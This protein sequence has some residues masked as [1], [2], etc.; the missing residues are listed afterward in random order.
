MPDIWDK[1][2]KDATVSDGGDW[3]PIDDDIYD[4]TIID[5][6]EPTTS[7][8][9]FN[10]DV[11]RTTFS[12]KFELDP[13][14]FDNQTWLYKW[15][16]LSPSFLESGKIHKKSALYE[17]MTSLGFDMDDPDLH[18]DP[19]EWIG[20]EARVVVKNVAPASGGDTRPRIVDIMPARPRKAA[21]RDMTRTGKPVAVAEPD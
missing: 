2:A 12:V 19:R 20:T 6:G 8:N 11:E 5:I 18:V 21:Q 16:A 1:Y 17:V 7:P 10:P 14:K 9:A 4:A 3:P 13:E 15:V